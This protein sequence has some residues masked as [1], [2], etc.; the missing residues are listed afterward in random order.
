[1]KNKQNK[2]EICQRSHNCLSSSQPKTH[3]CNRDKKE[4]RGLSSQLLPSSATEKT[5]CLLCFTTGLDC[6]MYKQDVAILP[7]A[8]NQAILI[9]KP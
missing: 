8:G 6:Q 1:M 7:T 5:T 4:V 2:E 9:V 3:I